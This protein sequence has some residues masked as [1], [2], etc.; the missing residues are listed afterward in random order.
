MNDHGTGCFPSIATLMIDTS[1]SN[2]A[3]ITHIKKASEAGFLDV[4]LHGYSGQKWKRNEYKISLP[5]HNKV[6][7]VSPEGGEPDDQKVVNEVHTNTPVNT[8]KNN[9]IIIKEFEYFWQAYGSHGSRKTALDKYIIV[10]RKTDQQTLLDA[11]KRYDQH[12]KIED[13]KKKRGCTVW[14]NQEGWVDVFP[15]APYV[16]PS[17]QM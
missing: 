15:S 3:V 12:L 8:P 10:R 9:K 2:K 6:V 11:N 17:W 1:L 16:K 14:L 5:N 13:W 4:S 7:N